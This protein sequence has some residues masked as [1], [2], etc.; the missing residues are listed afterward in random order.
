M[1]EPEKIRN[2]WKE[3]IEL[4]YNKESKPSEDEMEVELEEVES[5]SL[6]PE[7]LESEIEKSIK[8]MKDRKAVSVDD[9]PEEMSKALTC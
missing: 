3:Y 7:V 5:G 6:G 9:I 1:T 8:Q 2:R 4:L